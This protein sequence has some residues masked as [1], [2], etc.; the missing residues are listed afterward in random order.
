MS[1]LA[2]LVALVLGLGTHAQGGS[3]PDFSGTWALVHEEGA[4]TLVAA[5]GEA[6][7]ATQSATSLVVDRKALTPAGRGY[8]P[9]TMVERPVHSAFPFDGAESNITDLYANNGATHHQIFDTASW[10]GDKL[11]IARR[12]RPSPPFSVHRQLAIWLDRD[13]TLVVETSEVT[14]R[15]NDP[16]N[17]LTK[18]R[19]RQRVGISNASRGTQARGRC[20]LNVHLSPAPAWNRKLSI[21]TD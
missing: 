16:P 13:G 6:F 10:N 17:M 2:I 3:H 18:N 19:Y 11:V 4:V 5:F 20:Y 9:G 8:P 15:L 14:G 7:T 12:W 21:P 1:S